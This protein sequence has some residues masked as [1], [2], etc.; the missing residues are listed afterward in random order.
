MMTCNNRSKPEM[1]PSMKKL[2]IRWMVLAGL[3]LAGVGSSLAATPGAPGD[4]QAPCWTNGVGTTRQV[5]TLDTD[6][7]AGM[8]VSP[9]V[10]APSSKVNQPGS[11]TA[12]IA[13]SEFSGGW[14]DT[15]C[16]TFGFGC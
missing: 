15:A 9:A 14:V 11:P 12:T 4:S 3:V 8:N 6:A 2:R 7:S 16:N 13:W 5:W 10:Y 1:Q